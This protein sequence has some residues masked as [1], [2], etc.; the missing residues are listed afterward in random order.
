M[1]GALSL[2]TPLYSSFNLEE[3]SDRERVIRLRNS[4]SPGLLN[5]TLF[6]KIPVWQIV[7]EHGRGD[8]S[9]LILY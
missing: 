1:Y 6:K 2:T 5:R 3:P 8:I 9:R 7:E 4:R